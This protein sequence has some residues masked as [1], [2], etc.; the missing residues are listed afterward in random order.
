MLQ[1][2]PLEQW[3]H[4]E[5]QWDE[6]K[7]EGFFVRMMGINLNATHKPAWVPGVIHIKTVV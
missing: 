5:E 4:I 1:S 6:T 2:K 3:Y 7:E